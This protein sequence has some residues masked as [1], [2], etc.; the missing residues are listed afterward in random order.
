VIGFGNVGRKVAKL[1]NALEM[2]VLC[3]SRS[4]KDCPSLK[5]VLHRSDIVS[6]HLAYTEETKHFCNKDFFI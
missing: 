2:N 5:E 3:W 4:I 6:I 1:A